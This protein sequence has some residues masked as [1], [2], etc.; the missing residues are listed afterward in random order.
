M[1]SF[2]ALQA[3][4]PALAP[5]QDVWRRQFAEAIATVSKT[6]F[7]RVMSL[8]LQA[9][10]VTS[11]LWYRR[12][13]DLCE[14]RL[15]PK[16]P[17]T[18]ASLNNLALLLKATNRLAEAEPLMKRA[19]AI[20]KASYGPDHPEVAAGL[21]QSKRRPMSERLSTGCGSSPWHVGGGSDRVSVIHC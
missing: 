20:D 8:A 19:L 11:L 13:R 3:F 14:Q 7:P 9:E 18:A 15:G 17:Q 21:P 5:A 4:Q 16:H 10:Y 12:G 2:A 6:K 1:R